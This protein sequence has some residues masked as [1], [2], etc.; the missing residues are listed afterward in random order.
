MILQEDMFGSAHQAVIKHKEKI[1]ESK[2]EEIVLPTEDKNLPHT[3][4]KIFTN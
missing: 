4:V 2:L 3:S 1:E